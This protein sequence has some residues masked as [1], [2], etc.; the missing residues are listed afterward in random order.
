MVP[1]RV[2]LLLFNLAT[3]EDDPVLGFTSA[4]IRALATQCETVDVIT[5]RAGRLD[6]PAHVRVRSVGKER[7]YSIPRR[8]AEFYRLLFRALRDGRVDGCFSH[9][10]PAFSVL[11]G[12]VLRARAIPLVTWY[13]HP[14]L[15]RTLRLAHRW[16]DRMVASLPTAYPYRTDKLA[17]IG[18]GIDTD[19]FSPGSH[20]GAPP[21]V[22]CVGRL[23]PV[24]D[25]PTLI[26]AAARLHASGER[27]RLAIVGGPA[28]PADELYARE[29]RARADARGLG[30]LVDWVGPVA[31][32]ETVGWYRHCVA[33]VN[34]TRTGSGD[35]SA[36]EAMSCGRPSLAA[37]EGFRQT[38]GPHADRLLFPR[39]DADALAARLRAVLH[40]AP[41]DRAR[42]GQDLRARVVELHALD[43]LA[44]RLLEVLAEEAARKRQGRGA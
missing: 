38:L 39:G 35:K 28:T 29:L 36:L 22:L 43:R 12:P 24:K 1:H 5:M 40:L 44:R 30:A 16:S 3:D 20:E 4:W 42:I 10:M 7:G 13:A 32:G 19:L 34:L 8:V 21:L 33:H 18:Q 14:S 9:M 6:L 26:E 37:N 23:S 17:V 11:A 41:A 27:F 2:R 31:P 25:H 15:T